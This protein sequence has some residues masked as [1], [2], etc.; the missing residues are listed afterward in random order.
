MHWERV[1]AAPPAT[2]APTCRTSQHLGV[3]KISSHTRAPLGVFTEQTMPAVLNHV[4]PHSD[5][6][7]TTSRDGEDQILVKLHLQKNCSNFVLHH[8]AKF[9]VMRYIKEKV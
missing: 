4:K 3:Y 9:H 1:P 7:G 8:I 5:D 6:L 2:S